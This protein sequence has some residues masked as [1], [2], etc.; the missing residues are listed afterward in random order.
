MNQEQVEIYRRIDAKNHEAAESYVAWCNKLKALGRTQQPADNGTRGAVLARLQEI[1]GNLDEIVDGEARHLWL[2]AVT[3]NESTTAL[4]DAQAKHVLSE[5]A[6]RIALED[7]GEEWVITQET[8]DLIRAMTIGIAMEGDMTQSQTPSGPPQ[9]PGG[10][11]QGPPQNGP[12]GP[13]Q[14][15]QRSGPPDRAEIQPVDVDDSFVKRVSDAQWHQEAPLSGTVRVERDGYEWLLTLRAGVDGEMFRGFTQVLDGAT[16]FLSEHGFNPTSIA[17][18]ERAASASNGSP[19]A[20]SENGV[21]DTGA[22]QLEWVQTAR[23]QNGDEQVQ[24]QVAGFKWPM[25]D[26]RGVDFVV[27]NIFADDLGIQEN[28]VRQGFDHTDMLE[29]YGGPLQVDWQQ[30]VKGGR[31]YWDVLRVYR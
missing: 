26:S 25:K 9:T 12:G 20:Q 21:K 5:T 13:S 3:G 10:S 24:F 23:T 28:H 17:P 22:A 6:H 7:G 11:P 4:N 14:T 29:W 15:P 27:N 1:L 19:P 30:K 31:T 18:Q 2:E 8:A 16:R